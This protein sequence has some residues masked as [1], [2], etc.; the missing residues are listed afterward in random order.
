VADTAGVDTAIFNVDGG[1]RVV[2]A[3]SGKS[4]HVET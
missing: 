4:K 3:S 1:F 2:L